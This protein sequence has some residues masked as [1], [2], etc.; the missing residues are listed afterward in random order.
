[1]YLQVGTLNLQYCLYWYSV[2]VCTSQ[3]PSFWYRNSK[4][5]FTDT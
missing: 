5:E 1:M 4:P 2:D 3:V